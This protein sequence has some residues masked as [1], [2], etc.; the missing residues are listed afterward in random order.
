MNPARRGFATF[1]LTSHSAAGG[2][3]K[4]AQLLHLVT[5]NLDLDCSQQNCKHVLPQLPAPLDILIRI[6]IPMS[7]QTATIESLLHHSSPCRQASAT[8]IAPARHV[9]TMGIQQLIGASPDRL[10]TSFLIESVLHFIHQ[11]PTSTS[12]RK[13]NR[14]RRFP[15]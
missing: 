6:W 3:T 12:F 9:D 11:P 10:Q 5:W 15:K 2:L 14:F 1:F 13:M 8:Y 7:F 4:S